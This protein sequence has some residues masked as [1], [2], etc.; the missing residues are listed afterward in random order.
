MDLT[1][2]PAAAAA[3]AWRE[4]H[5]QARSLTPVFEPA[6]VAVLGVSRRRG[7][8]GREVLENILAAGFDGPVFAIGHPALDITGVSC[9][10]SAD[11]LPPAVDLVVVA[12]P[13]AGVEDSVRVAAERGARSCVILTSGL[14]ET[15]A[16]GAA[17]EGRLTRIAREHDMRLLG[18]NCFG[19]SSS[20][21]GSKLDATFAVT[22]PRAGTIA[23]A[24]QSGGVGIALMDAARDRDLGLACFVS[25]GNMADVS[26]GDL[27]AAWTD[28]VGVDAAVLYL[29][30][31]HDPRQFARTAATFSRDKPLLVVFGGSSVT[32]TRAGASHTAASAT[33]ERVLRALFRAAGAV[34]VS[35]VRELVDTAALL[36]GQPL[37]LGPRLGILDNAGGLGIVAADSASRRS[38]DVPELGPATRSRLTAAVP[39]AAAV[40]NPVDL[41]A[42]AGARSFAQAA[43]VLLASGE[44]DA[45]LTIVA[46]TAVTDLPGITT[47]VDEATA[48]SPT[49]PCLTVIVGADTA[50]CHTTRFGSVEDATT[51]LAHAVRYSSWLA[52]ADRDLVRTE[53]DPALDRT[54]TAAD[55]DGS[56]WL[57]PRAARDLLDSIGVTSVPGRSVHTDRGADKAIRVLGYPLVVKAGSASVLH[58]T[59]RSLVH[60]GLATRRMV[61]DAVHDIQAVCGTDEPVLVQQ[62]LSGPE[63][64]VGLVRNAEFGPL[65]MVASGGTSLD[66]WAD[67]TYLMPPLARSDVRSALEGL[68]TWPLLTGFRGGQVLDVD[69][70]VDLVMAVGRLALERPDVREVDLNPVI[71]TAAGPVCVDAKVCVCGSGATEAG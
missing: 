41:G 24:S 61:L 56:H 51:A 11:Q 27:L 14:G 52:A 8:V 6:S 9:L 69:A 7:R 1:V 5:A 33:P 10:P 18:P 2:S 54:W 3:A 58:K 49:I 34:D 46:P 36:T 48:G 12:T 39:D 66:L 28:D 31:F 55:A 35:S 23:V 67:Q 47:A 70:T 59:E 68:R 64:A 62:E 50:P 57:G 30:S 19:V 32:G 38:L 42:A 60:T 44:V 26:G 17:V 16:D 43:R 13:P 40:A 45:L 53:V 63:L 20:L 71:I 65:V 37:P 22:R 21:R 25:L 29:E 4:R 15:G